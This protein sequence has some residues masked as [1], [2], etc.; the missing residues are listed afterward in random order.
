MISVYFNAIN[1]NRPH[2]FWDAGTGGIVFS[3]YHIPFDETL[4][5]IFIDVN[6]Q[7]AILE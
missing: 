7:Y 4:S 5:L 2:N 1:V 6:T 3:P